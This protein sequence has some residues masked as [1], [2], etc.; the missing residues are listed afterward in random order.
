MSALDKVQELNRLIQLYDTAIERHDSHLR[1]AIRGIGGSVQM[2]RE[3]YVALVRGDLK[4]LKRK[5]SELEHEVQQL[6]IKAIEDSFD[7]D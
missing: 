7:D 3:K 6:E 2:S 1:K 4:L 5:K